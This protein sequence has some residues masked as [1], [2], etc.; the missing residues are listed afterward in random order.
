MRNGA[1]PARRHGS[2]VDLTQILHWEFKNGRDNPAH[3]GAVLILRGNRSMAAHRLA[4]PFFHQKDSVF[5]GIKSFLMTNLGLM[6]LARVYLLLINSDPSPSPMP[7]SQ[8][9][10]IFKFP[11]YEVG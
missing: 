8:R 1:P 5:Y 3:A 6:P 9:R 11:M 10:S 4:R 2:G 7:L